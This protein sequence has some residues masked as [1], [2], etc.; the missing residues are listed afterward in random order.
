M[1]APW[2]STLAIDRSEAVTRMEG[3]ASVWCVEDVQVKM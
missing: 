3:S 2:Q 1:I